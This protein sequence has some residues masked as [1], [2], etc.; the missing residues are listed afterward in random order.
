MGNN[1]HRSR[2]T[3]PEPYPEVRVA[4]RNLFYAQLLLDDYASDTSELNAIN[5][6]LYHYFRFKCQD[7]EDI[8]ELEEGISIVEMRHLEMLAETILMLGGDPRYRGFQNNNQQY[9]TSSYVYYGYSVLDML[10]SDIDAERGAIVQ[11]R[12][13]AEQISDPY[14]R[15]LLNRIIKDE[16]Y[17]LKLF[18]EA[19]Q[20][21][22]SLHIE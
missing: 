20:R 8:A 5:Q 12:R 21:Y 7:L 2:Y 3:L 14:V 19:Y 16:E 18:T 15:A 10:S 9:Y 1:M 4:G 11:Y 6:Y 17:H 13:H 22:Q